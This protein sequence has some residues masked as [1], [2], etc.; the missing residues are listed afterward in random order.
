MKQLSTGGTQL[1]NNRAAQTRVGTKS[2]P[3]GGGWTRCCCGFRW[4]REGIIGSVQ[5]QDLFDW[6]L[7][8]FFVSG[9]VLR[10]GR[11]AICWWPCWSAGNN[12]SSIQHVLLHSTQIK[13]KSTQ[14]HFHCFTVNIYAVNCYMLIRLYHRGFWFKCL[15]RNSIPKPLIQRKTYVYRYNTFLNFLQDQKSSYLYGKYGLY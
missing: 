5:T 9:S 11:T 1:T 12:T 7:R 13:H 2:E 4:K 15:K 10:C 3:W 14:T 8:S 6:A